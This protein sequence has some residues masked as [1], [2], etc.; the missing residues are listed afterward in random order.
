MRRR[1]ARSG[2]RSSRRNETRDEIE[3]DRRRDFASDSMSEGSFAPFLSAG[4][5]LILSS[6]GIFSSL[7]L[8]LLS[9]ERE[10]NCRDTGFNTSSR[11]IFSDY[12]FLRDCTLFREENKIL[13]KFFYCIVM[14]WNHTILFGYFVWQQNNSALYSVLIL[15]FYHNYICILHHKLLYS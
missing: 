12:C 13:V 8:C 3:R 5:R 1:W 14:S 2:P 6:T 4:V 7:L 10:P 9:S 15:V 11:G